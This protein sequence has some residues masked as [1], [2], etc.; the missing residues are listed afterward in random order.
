MLPFEFASQEF[1]DELAFDDGLTTV[2]YGELETAISESPVM[3]LDLRPGQHIAWC[4]QN[5]KDAFITFWALIKRGC[6]ACPINYRFPTLTRQEIVGRID[7]LWLPDEIENAKKY[8]RRHSPTSSTLETDSPAT[9]ILSSGSTGTPKAVVHSMQAHIVNA[10]GSTRNIPLEPGD[11]WFWTLPLCHISGLSILFRCALAAATVVGI[12]ADSKLTDQLIDQ[13]KITHLSAVNT[14]LRRLI[15]E[16]SFPPKS[17]RTILLGGSATDPRLVTDTRERGV[18]TLT[19]YGLTEMASQVATSEPDSISESSGEVLEGREIKITEDNKI[20]VRGET[21][22]LG[23]YSDGTIN[24]VVDKKGWFATGDMGYVDGQNQLFVKGRI[25]NLFISGGENVY[26]ENIE[27]V[28]LKIFD[29]EQVII[30]PKPDHEFGERPVAFVNGELPTDWQAQ[31]RPH[32][33]NYEIPIEA[34]DWPETRDASIKPNRQWI[35]SLLLNQT[36]TG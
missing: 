9:I 20:L 2:K 35:K 29:I 5:D 11:R 24:P 30:A 10:R 3:H 31:L 7:A 8:Q 4:P 34:L 36:N 15:N 17:L 26:P 16:P 18:T 14:Q 22:C 21:L 25:D 33:A 6:V 1:P 27:R 28:M 13:H 32:L 19:T 12:Q 23:Y